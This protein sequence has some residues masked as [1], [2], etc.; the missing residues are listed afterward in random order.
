MKC[1]G[2]LQKLRCGRKILQT[3]LEVLSALVLFEQKYK[4]N[5]NIRVVVIVLS[6]ITVMALG[7]YMREKSTESKGDSPAESTQTAETIE[8]GVRALRERRGRVDRS[9]GRSRRAKVERNNA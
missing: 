9:R 2:V 4:S 7:H 6:S 8:S 1:G 5:K 3:S